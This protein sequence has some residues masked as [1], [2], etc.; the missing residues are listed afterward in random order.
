MNLM[1][2]FDVSTPRTAVPLDRAVGDG[3]TDPAFANVMSRCYG[4]DAD[5]LTQSDAD[6]ESESLQIESDGSLTAAVE[7]A[8]LDAN[9]VVVDPTLNPTIADCLGSG[10][11][12]PVLIGPD[13]QSLPPTVD[14]GAVL[15]A[16]SNVLDYLRRPGPD[17]QLDQID[18]GG[19]TLFAAQLPIP[20]TAPT[21]LGGTVAPV[22]V[23]M[24]AIVDAG[25]ARLTAVAGVST[26][27]TPTGMDAGSASSAPGDTPLPSTPAVADREPLD[28][29]DAVAKAV[30][31]VV[32]TKAAPATGI[33]TSDAADL[34]DESRAA[35]VRVFVQASTAD[36][37]KG[38]TNTGT[39]QQGDPQGQPD[40]ALRG[41]AAPRFA[42]ARFAAAV[43][44]A[45]RLDPIDLQPDASIDSIRTDALAPRATTNDAVR[46]LVST[47]LGELAQQHAPRLAGE[48]ADRVLLLRGQ[49]F[50]SATV[51]LEPRDLGRI[52]IQVRL[53]ADATHITFT[54]QHSSVRDAL[55][56]QL[57]RLRAL[58][59]EAGL[60]L[61]M[62]DVS[63]SDS[64]N[65]GE[66][67]TPRHHEQ[68]KSAA[69]GNSDV[70]DS[71]MRWQRRIEA[72]IIDLHA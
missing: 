62:V 48:L 26:A 12:L 19:A 69:V 44:N 66:A 67:S 61:G 31:S 17:N 28:D 32:V 41:E 20:P 9:G 10:G 60:S 1:A 43:S 46:D 29:I 40:D 68:S 71:S 5:S 58:L 11:V 35:Q 24:P 72:S 50:D 22:P 47:R 37:G 65:P 8:G 7:L 21:S 57:P 64:R 6:P 25:A 2:L 52:D 39:G 42:T 49:R 59:E 4:N 53:Q 3:G 23:P 18:Q 54:A 16:D 56:G 38:S 36:G 27:T 30:Y 63:Q 70:S 45:T 14:A 55:E 51:V 34:R 33:Q 13:G 15:D